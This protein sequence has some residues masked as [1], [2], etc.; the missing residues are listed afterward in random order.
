MS[1]QNQP[2]GRHPFPDHAGRPRGACSPRGSRPDAARPRPFRRPT[3]LFRAPRRR[4]PRPPSRRRTNPPSRPMLEEGGGLPVPGPSWPWTPALA[5]AR[6]PRGASP[7][8][9]IPWGGHPATATAFREGHDSLA[10]PRLTT[11]R[12]VRRSAGP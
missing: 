10:R 8:P 11:R 2:S 6:G 9:L 12:G 3:S 7:R 4:R 5:L 1:Q